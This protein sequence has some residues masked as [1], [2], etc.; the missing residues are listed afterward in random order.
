MVKDFGWGVNIYPPFD[1]F[2]NALERV[3]VTHLYLHI[4]LYLLQENIGVL[5]LTKVVANTPNIATVGGAGRFYRHKGVF[6][7][8]PYLGNNTLCILPQHHAY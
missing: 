6:I 5:E 8:A 1:A 2:P 7:H 3:R 4:S